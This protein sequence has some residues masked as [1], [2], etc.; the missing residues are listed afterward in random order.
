PMPIDYPME[1]ARAIL[2][3]SY[4]LGNRPQDHGR[5]A[6]AVV[7]SKTENAKEVIRLYIYEWKDGKLLPQDGTMMGAGAPVANECARWVCDGDMPQ[8]YKKGPMCTDAMLMCQAATEMGSPLPACDAATTADCMCADPTP[9]PCGC[10]LT[11][12][13]QTEVSLNIADLDHDG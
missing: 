5:P 4:D 3:F 7:T 12:E 6:L 11:V 10:K 13:F 2:G 1:T 9:K 8:L